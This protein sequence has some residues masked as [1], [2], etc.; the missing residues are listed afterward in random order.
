MTDQN[1]GPQGVAPQPGAPQYGAPQY[2]GYPAP[3][4]TP[5]RPPL[6][7]GE[8]KGA[9]LAGAV[10]FNLLTLGFTVF[11]IPIAVG[12]FGGFLVWMLSVAESR[13]Q[14]LDDDFYFRAQEFL[15]SLNI[16]LLIAL[17][18]AMS[19]IG[20]A[21]MAG[22]LFASRKILRSF[23]VIKAWPIT[24]SAAG[25]AIFAFS[26]L[27]QIPVGIAQISTYPMIMSGV[28]GVSSTIAAAV[29]WFILTIALTTLFGWLAWWWMT[30]A[31]RPAT[32]DNA[33]QAIVL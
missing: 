29:V 3:P 8:K 11:V 7:R 2:V 15:G 32:R 16:G 13:T 17:G 12:L 27:G 33:P 6:T 31:F 14:G 18:I 19:L 22:G 20:L 28:D 24:W 26:I 5:A 21:I 25:I 10:G 30:F 9:F 4:R 23:G 1:A